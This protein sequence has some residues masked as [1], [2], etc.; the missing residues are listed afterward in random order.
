MMSRASNKCGRERVTGEPE[1]NRPLLR[2]R[3]KLYLRKYGRI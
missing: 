2:Q 3:I 1:R